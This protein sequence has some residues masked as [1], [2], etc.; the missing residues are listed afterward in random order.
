M[1]LNN[2]SIINLN[3]NDNKTIYKIKKNKIDNSIQIF[4]IT[5]NKYDLVNKIFFNNLIYGINND[6]INL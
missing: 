4:N 6:V 3:D 2:K 5:D 1:K